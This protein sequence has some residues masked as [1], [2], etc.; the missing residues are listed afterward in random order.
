MKEK[1]EILMQ[2][3]RKENKDNRIQVTGK[4]KVGHGGGAVTGKERGRG[5]WHRYSKYS[6]IH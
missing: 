5:R 4:Q 1:M 6:S 2:G 3:Q